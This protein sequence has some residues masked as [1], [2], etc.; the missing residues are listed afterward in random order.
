LH[1]PLGSAPPAGT[2]AQLP[3][4]PDNAQDMQRPAQAVAQQTPWAQ[5]PDAHWV[6]VEQLAPFPALPQELPRQLLPAAQFASVVQLL[7]QRLP[8]H[9][10][11]A[12]V[13]PASATHCPAPSQVAE[14]V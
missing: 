8:L 6:P 5:I 9:A 1:V 3:S 10:K 13:L 4:L 7:K 2:T 11:G 14:A 12:Q